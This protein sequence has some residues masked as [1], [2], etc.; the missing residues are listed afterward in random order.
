[1]ANPSVIVPPPPTV[2]QPSSPSSDTSPGMEQVQRAFDSAYPDIKPAK[3]PTPPAEEP[4]PAK[5][6]DAKPE[7]P[8]PAAPTEPETLPPAATE[9]KPAEE[10]IPSFLEEALKL[11][12]TVKPPAEPEAADVETEWP[13]DLPPEQKQSR[14]KGLRD[15]YKNLK[16]KLETLEKRPA[17][18]PAQ[19]DR[20]AFLETNNKQ[21]AEILS[22]VGV[23]HSQEFQQNI[24][25]PLTA[26]WNEAARIVK[27]SGGDPQNLA[28][29]MALSGRAQFEALDE[30]FQDMPESAKAEAHDALRNYRRYEDARRRAVAD[31]PKTLEQLR[32]RETERQYQE[33][34]KQREEMKG[35]FDR[36]L[37]RLRDEAKV[38][39]FQTT[40]DPEAKWW[41]D[42]SEQIVAQ[43]RSLFLENTD[44]DKVAMACLLAPTADAYRKLFI[45]SQK[46][47]GE[48]QKII[49]DKIGN[50]PNLSESAGPG[51][52][53]SADQTKVDLNEPFDKVFLREFHKQREGRQ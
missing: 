53:T 6:P 26:S 50:E 11:D 27:D 46:R 39:V 14:I 15:A 34:N 12:S 41:N 23:E 16:T 51:A 44:M 21:M 52:R 36:A 24:I 10:K 43:A 35:M 25:A 29:A 20:L 47:I 19:A 4:P 1:M 17:V 49:N 28:K 38:E 40:T 22:R 32:H 42:Q 37:S 31:A 45:K 30:L 7:T 3:A 48:L 18:D 9:K 13:E 33:L 8:P 2:V 5:Q